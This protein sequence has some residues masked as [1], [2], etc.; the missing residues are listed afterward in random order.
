MDPEKDWKHGKKIAMNPEKDWENES[1]DW[2]KLNLI[3]TS[4]ALFT[5]EF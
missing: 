5:R 2:D 4:I 1:K 3:W